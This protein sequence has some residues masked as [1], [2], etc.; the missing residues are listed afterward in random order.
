MKDSRQRRVSVAVGRPIEGHC[1]QSVK[2][3]GNS[4]INITFRPIQT[5]SINVDAS[6]TVDEEVVLHTVI[7]TASN[8]DPHPSLREDIPIHECTAC[9][10]IQIDGHDVTIV[11]C[12]PGR[13]NVMEE[14]ET[15]DVS[16]VCPI[17]SHVEGSGVARV[18]ADGI[19]IVVFE[20]IVI[21]VQYD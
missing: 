15:H 13:T 5:A 1:I 12:S 3:G 17:A 20:H 10:I 2:E 14:V 8:E 4:S 11:R 16:S 19:D 9:K 7:S 21:A 18:K 6:H